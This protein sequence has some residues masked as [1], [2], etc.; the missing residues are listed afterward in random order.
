[1]RDVRLFEAQR[2]RSHESLVL[3]RLSCEALTHVCD[4]VDHSLPALLLALARLHHL[5]HLV[6]ACRRHLRDGHAPLARLLLPLLLDRIG[7]HLRVRHALTVEQEGRHRVVFLR[8]LLLRMLVHALGMLLD[9]LLHGR[10]LAV[11]FCVELL[12][13]EAAHLLGDRRVLVGS[14]SRLLLAL[15]LLMVQLPPIPP[16]VQL[17]VVA[18]RHAK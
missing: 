4:L 6:L 16:A 12:R 9:L 3:W 8:S 2:R 18:L 10:L 14:I 17:N 15:T 7:E 13:L 11:P 1:V 5:E